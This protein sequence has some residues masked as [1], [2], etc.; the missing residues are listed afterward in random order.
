M[1]E[2]LAVQTSRIATLTSIIRTRKG[3]AVRR[4]VHGGS[5]L[6]LSVRSEAVVVRLERIAEKL[7]KQVA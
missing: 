3:D 4:E 1:T 2:E 5:P 7:E 6:D